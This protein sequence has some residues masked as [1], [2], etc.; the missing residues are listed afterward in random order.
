MRVVHGGTWRFASG[1]D[2][3][4]DAAAK[5]ASQAVAMAKLSAQVIKAAGSDERVELAAEP[6]PQPAA[7]PVAEK[8]AKAAA[9]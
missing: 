1:V 2:L 5:V 8:P 3:S 6:A 7:E 9:E 4:L